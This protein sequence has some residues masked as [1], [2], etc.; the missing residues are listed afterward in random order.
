MFDLICRNITAHE[1]VVIK[2]VEGHPRVDN[3]RDVLKRLQHRT[4]FL[5]PLIDEIEKPSTPTTIAL[6]Y[7]ESDVLTETIKKT[8]SRKE[9]KHVCRSV[10]ETLKVLHE[11]NLVHTGM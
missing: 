10:L 7:L 8:L 9:L 2:G 6:K 5:R 1:T 3:E 11:E 4:P